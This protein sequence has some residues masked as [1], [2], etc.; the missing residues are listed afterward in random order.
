MQRNDMPHLGQDS[1]VKSTK[2]SFAEKYIECPAETF[3]VTFR[4]SL[5]GQINKFFYRQKCCVVKCYV[6]FHHFPLH[7]SVMLFW[8]AKKMQKDFV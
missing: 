3:Y 8:A 6:T 7:F 1:R 2:E 4:A 5:K